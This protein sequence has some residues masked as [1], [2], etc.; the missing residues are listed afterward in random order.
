MKCK[1]FEAIVELEIQAVSNYISVINRNFVF[2]N[3]F[4]R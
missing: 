2:K 1:A 3:V 4:D